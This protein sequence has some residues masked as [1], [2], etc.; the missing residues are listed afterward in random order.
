MTE[1]HSTAFAHSVVPVGVSG[2]SSYQTRL[3]SPDD[4][5]RRPLKRAA[6]DVS[7]DEEEIIKRVRA[8]QDGSSNGSSEGSPLLHVDKKKPG[9]KPARDDEPIDKRTAQNRAAQRAFR[10]RKEKYVKA[11]EA[12][13]LELQDALKATKVPDPLVQRQKEESLMEENARLRQENAQMGQKLESLE[14]QLRQV[15]NTCASTTIS[16]PVL[17]PGVPYTLLPM[18]VLPNLT[19]HP[20]LHQGPPPGVNFPA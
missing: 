4:E 7:T 2:H 18:P 20:M 17:D 6:E 1:L 8:L 14:R 12:R 3:L 9:R 16:K 11:L 15:L 5:E 19:S 10:E 13:V